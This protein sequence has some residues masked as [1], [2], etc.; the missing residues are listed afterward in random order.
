[1]YMQWLKMCPASLRL[2]IPLLLP[3]QGVSNL[4]EHVAGHIQ[5]KKCMILSIRRDIMDAKVRHPADHFSL[6]VLFVKSGGTLT[7]LDSSSPL[8]HIVN[9]S[10]ILFYNSIS[11]IR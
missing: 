3:M 4:G 6:A 11:P 7:R 9:I 10:L 2:C 5:G 1:M 8:E